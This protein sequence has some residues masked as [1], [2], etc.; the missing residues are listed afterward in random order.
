MTRPKSLAQ[1][2]LEDFGIEFF[3]KP[4][5]NMKNSLMRLTDKLL[6]RKRFMALV[7]SE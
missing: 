7:S 4:R 2:L 6:S 3:A 1:K 5:R